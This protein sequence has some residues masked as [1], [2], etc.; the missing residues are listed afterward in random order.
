ME[1]K[2]IWKEAVR[3][4][5]EKTKPNFLL[6]FFLKFQEVVNPGTNC[7]RHKYLTSLHD[8]VMFALIVCL[9]VN[10]KNCQFLE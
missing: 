6:L 9:S 3:N 7:Y 8:H 10:Y 5:E 4:L 2:G 1:K